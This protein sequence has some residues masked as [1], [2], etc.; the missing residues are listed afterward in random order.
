MEDEKETMERMSLPLLFSPHNFLGKETHP[1]HR[2]FDILSQPTIAQPALARRGEV[3]TLSLSK[4]ATQFWGMVGIGNVECEKGKGDLTYLEHPH[5]S[6]LK[7]DKRLGDIK[8]LL[9]SLTPFK[10]NLSSIEWPSLQ[11]VFSVVPTF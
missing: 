11:L 4:R 5:C 10:H 3:L 6:L 2:R 9:L 8:R 1:T 7:P